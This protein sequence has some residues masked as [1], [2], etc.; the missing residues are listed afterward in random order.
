MKTILTLFSF[1]TLTAFVGYGQDGVMNATKEHKTFTISENGKEKQFSVKVM[2]HRDYAV[3]LNKNDKGM[4]NQDRKPVPAFV[5]KLIAVDHDADT[6][7]DSYTVLKYKGSEKNTFE[8]APTSKGFEIKVDDRKMQYNVLDDMYYIK[9]K[10]KDFFMI[11]EFTE[12]P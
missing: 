3:K 12:A 2:E 8:L 10:N 7:F 11:E 1:F 6:D 4:V 5:T 9:D